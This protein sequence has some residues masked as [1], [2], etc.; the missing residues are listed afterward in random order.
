M[1]QQPDSLLIHKLRD[2]IAQHRPD[3]IKP[4]VRLANVLQAHIVQQNLLHDEDGDG[5]AQLA[6]GLHDAQ[7]Q[8]DD[9]GREQEVDDVRGVVFDQRADHAEGG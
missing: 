3:R 6:A 7:A 2:H 9:L 4:L 8:R 5:F 1:L